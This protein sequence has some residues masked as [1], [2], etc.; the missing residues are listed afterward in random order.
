[1]VPSKLSSFMK[2][3]QIGVWMSV[4]DTALTWILWSA[5]PWPSAVLWHEVQPRGKEDAGGV[6]EVLNSY[7]LAQ[8]IDFCDVRRPQ[9]A[10]RKVDSL[11]VDLLYVLLE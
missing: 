3:L 8:F 7:A 2:P 10:A 6:D 5:L 9:L 11:E 4:G 1:M